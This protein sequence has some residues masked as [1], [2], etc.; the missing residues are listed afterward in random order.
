MRKAVLGLA[1]LLGACSAAQ[2]QQAQ[3]DIASGIQAACADVNAAVKLNPNS[4]A[5]PWAVGAC[6]TAT[7]VA[8]LV[9]NSATI[10]WLGQVQQQLQAPVAATKAA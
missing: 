2:L 5:A 6:G 9:Q 10:Q 3:T 1:L 4:P 7:A 8:A